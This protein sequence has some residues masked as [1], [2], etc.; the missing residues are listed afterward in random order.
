MISLS[1]DGKGFIIQIKVEIFEF[2]LFRRFIRDR[3]WIFFQF[4][5]FESFIGESEDLIRDGGIEDNFMKCLTFINDLCN[6]FSTLFT[7]DMNGIEVYLS[8]SFIVNICKFSNGISPWVFFLMSFD[9]VYLYHL[10]G[11]FPEDVDPGVVINWHDDSKLKVVL[12]AFFVTGEL[13]LW[14]LE[15]FLHLACFAD[16]PTV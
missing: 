8:I 13:E 3:G 16:F 9:G 12:G 11:A 6:L 15:C 1:A 7:D 14:G 5:I 10:I 4:P 2:I